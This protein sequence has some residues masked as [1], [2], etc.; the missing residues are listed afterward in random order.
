MYLQQCS[1]KGCIEGQWGTTQDYSTYIVIRGLHNPL[2]SSDNNLCKGNTPL[3]SSTVCS[4]K[5]RLQHCEIITIQ[6]A[7][8]SS[9]ATLQ[10]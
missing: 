3:V 6:C 7:F 10:D 9:L 2:S 5:H 8:K 4:V 1:T